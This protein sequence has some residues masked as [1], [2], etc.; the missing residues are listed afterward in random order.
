MT[1]EERDAIDGQCNRFGR[2]RDLGH[3][4]ALVDAH[5][6]RTGEPLLGV[7]EAKLIFLRDCTD[8]EMGDGDAARMVC[9]QITS[10][11]GAHREQL[12]GVDP[13][14]EIHSGQL[15]WR[16]RGP[17]APLIRGTHPLYLQPPVAPAPQFDAMA[18]E[19]ERLAVEFCHE[20]AQ[21]RG[22]TPVRLLEMAQALYGAEINAR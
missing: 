3:L 10:A 12:G 11:I 4:M 2:P 5:A 21:H 7:I 16:S 18:P 9:E 17:D 15:L 19:Q 20:I 8:Y 22:L 1:P 14:A 13:V 6:A